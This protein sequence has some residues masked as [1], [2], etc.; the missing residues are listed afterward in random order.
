MTA[1]KNSAEINT[2]QLGSTIRWKVKSF[3]QKFPLP[4][5]F[6]FANCSHL[7]FS[8][9]YSFGVGGKKRNF[10]ANF[11]PPS[12]AKGEIVGE[13]KSA[14]KWH[15]TKIKSSWTLPPV[16]HFARLWAGRGGCGKR[17]RI[18]FTSFVL[19]RGNGFFSSFP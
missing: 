11:P 15:T 9:L 17:I 14:E 8:L 12:L 3:L 2:H 7:P 10:S 6:V 16:E 1:R 4:A 5:I 18:M 19:P 13:A